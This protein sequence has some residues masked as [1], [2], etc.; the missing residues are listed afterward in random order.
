MKS[1]VSKNKYKRTN[2]QCIPDVLGQGKAGRFTALFDFQIVFNKILFRK[3]R[4]L[5]GDSQY[6][7]TTKIK[8]NLNERERLSFSLRFLRKFQ[9]TL[10]KTTGWNKSEK[11]TKEK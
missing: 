3:R 10:I 9:K 6:S 4:K 7:V 5:Y 11:Q 8:K 2:L 1:V